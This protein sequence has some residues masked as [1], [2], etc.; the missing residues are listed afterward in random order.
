LRS[1]LL[2]ISQ[3]PNLLGKILAIAQNSDEK[4]E[5]RPAAF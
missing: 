1:Q 5:K 4:N 3:F 2:D